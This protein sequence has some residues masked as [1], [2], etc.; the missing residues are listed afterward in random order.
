MQDS[1]LANRVNNLVIKGANIT[2]TWALKP[3]CKANSLANRVNNLVIKG[4][5]ITATW[6]LKPV[7]KANSPG[8]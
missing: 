6:A 2:A 7:C 8:G 3:V 4:A 1:N 5:N